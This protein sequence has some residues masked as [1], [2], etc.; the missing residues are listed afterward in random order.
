MGEFE[1]LAKLR[2]R[3]P[4][5]GPQVK[6]GSGD[7]AAVTAPAGATATSVD[8]IVEGVHFR[9]GE[10]ELRTVGRK[11]LATA[12]SD[13]AAMGAEAGE[14]YVVLGAPADLGEE[15]FLALL[16]GMLE[17]AAETGTTIA[18]GDVTRAPAL[19]L[20]V[21]VVGH[22]AAADA[23]VTRAGAQ[24]GDLLVLTG[25]IGAAAAGRLLLEHPALAAELPE[26]TARELRRRQLDPMPRLRTGLA[27]AGS[28]ATAMIDLSDGLAAD[29][30]HLAR[31]GGVALQIQADSLPLAAGVAEVAAAAGRDPIELAVAGGEDYELLAAL[32]PDRLV[33]ASD[34]SGEAGE[35][36]LTPIG[37]VVVGEGVEIR[38]PRGGQLKAAGFDHFAGPERG[39][40]PEA[41]ERRGG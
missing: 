28:G 10:A 21:T 20:A 33:P 7:D 23:F 26:S 37:E 39:S 19:T 40:Q 31:A 1:F 32:P 11:A 34:A 17:L 14:A 22:A 36:K 24:P 13:L 25:E 4:P 38:L 6:L 2:E 41:R 8:A 29:A 18:G 5:D 35:A 12:L 27:L 30:G 15:D 3:L 16:D 9:R